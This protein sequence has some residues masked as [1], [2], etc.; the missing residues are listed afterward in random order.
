MMHAAQLRGGGRLIFPEQLR[1]LP[2]FTL[3]L[4]KS[5]AIRGGARDV[6]PDERIVVGHE[7]VAAPVELLL[8]MLY[9]AAYPLHDPA[10]DWG[11]PAEVGNALWCGA[12]CCLWCCC[13][14]SMTAAWRASPGALCGALLQR[15]RSVSM[16]Q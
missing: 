4:L 2:I 10:G 12:V 7:L 1:Y 15:E 6:N 8:R 9:P 13:C 3:G 11:Q 16:L 14:L 5:T